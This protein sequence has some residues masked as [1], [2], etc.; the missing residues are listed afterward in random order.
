MLPHRTDPDPISKEIQLLPKKLLQPDGNPETKRHRPKL[1]QGSDVELPLL[2]ENRLEPD[3]KREMER[4]WPEPDSV[5]RKRTDLDP[6]LDSDGENLLLPESRPEPDSKILHQN[7]LDTDSDSNAK[8]SDGSILD[9]LRYL[10]DY[11]ASNSETLLT[12]ADLSLDSLYLEVSDL[13]PEIIKSKI[14]D[15]AVQVVESKGIWGMSRPSKF[16]VY[17]P[18]LDLL[19]LKKNTTIQ[20]SRKPIPPLNVGSMRSDALFVLLVE[21]HATFLRLAEDKFYNRF[22]CIIITARGYPDVATRMFLRRLRMELHLPVLALMDSDPHGVKI[23]SVYGM[24]PSESF[25][26]KSESVSGS[27]WCNILPSGIGQFSGRSKFSPSE[28]KS[29]SRSVRFRLTESGSANNVPSHAYRWVPD[30][31]RIGAV[32][33]R[34][35]P[36]TARACDVLSQGY[37]WVT[38]ASWVE[39]VFLW[40]PSLSRFGGEGS[41]TYPCQPFLVVEV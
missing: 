4:Y 31:S 22:P 24:V 7:D 19:V 39:A 5:K 11:S 10:R 15:I 3:S 21:K 26:S 38:E 27:F 35:S 25:A 36:G 30:G 16:Q 23:L 13:P 2:S 28:S 32:I 14:E 18:E 40:I 6:N 29:G 33:L 34:R 9:I 41:F 17:I 12:L 1:Y 8:D 37:R 20:S